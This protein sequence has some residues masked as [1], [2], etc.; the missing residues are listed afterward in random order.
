MTGRYVPCQKTRIVGCF[1]SSGDGT[2][3]KGVK[4]R[5]GEASYGKVLERM[6]GILCSTGTRAAEVL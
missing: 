2:H 4:D 3:R 5:L 6:T 1:G